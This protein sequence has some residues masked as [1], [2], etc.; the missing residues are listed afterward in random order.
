[1]KFWGSDAEMGRSPSWNGD[2]RN[3]PFCLEMTSGVIVA[4]TVEKEVK[5]RLTLMAFGAEF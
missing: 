3:T 5:A 2:V 4:L 1:M